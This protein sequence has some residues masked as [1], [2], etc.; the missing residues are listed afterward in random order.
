[1]LT[2]RKIFKRLYSK[3][4]VKILRL[5]AFEGVDQTSSFVENKLAAFVE[6]CLD[7]ISQDHSEFKTKVLRLL[8]DF[9]KL[10]IQSSGKFITEGD[11][12]EL[13]NEIIIKTMHKNL[14][15]SG[16]FL[17]QGFVFTDYEIESSD[18]A[19]IALQNLGQFLENEKAINSFEI[20][21]GLKKLLFD[22]SQTFLY[23]LESDV[24][25]DSDPS[26]KKR[27]GPNPSVLPS[28]KFLKNRSLQSIRIITSRD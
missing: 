5:D 25:T 14:Y 26:L 4:V 27:A 20:L 8:N 22:Q 15:A 12:D 6:I 16:Q 9:A 1:M 17:Q 19:L 11:F 13:H 7:L 3:N 28:L 10:R 24:P 23:N 21:E 2:I 18:L